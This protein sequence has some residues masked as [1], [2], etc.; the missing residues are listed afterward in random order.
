MTSPVADF[1]HIL[2]FDSPIDK[3]ARTQWLGLGIFY[4]SGRDRKSN[5]K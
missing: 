5:K 3:S 1:P 4:Y 2:H